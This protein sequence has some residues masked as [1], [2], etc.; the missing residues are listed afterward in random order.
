M[1]S[2]DNLS[3]A[4]QAYQEIRHELHLQEEPSFKSVKNPLDNR[5][6]VDTSIIIG[7][8]EDGQPLVINLYDYQLG[9][10]LVAGDKGC[11][12]TTFLHSTAIHSATLLDVQ[13]GV[14]TPFPEEWREH[15]TLPNCLGIWPAQHSSA[16]DFLA[17]VT[18]WAEVLPKTRQFILV[19]VDNLEMMSFHSRIRN[20]FRWLCMQGPKHHVWPVVAMNPSKINTSRSFLDQFRT[21]IL[22]HMGHYHNACLLSGEPPLDLRSLITGSQFFYTSSRNCT[23]FWL[24]PAEGLANERGNALVR[25]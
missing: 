10:V 24:P 5:T 19:L 18:H 7:L 22:G 3:I 15:E 16:G 1:S 6:Y 23:R 13:F 2:T 25:Q 4:L 14:L 21:R 11:G 8:A 20:D 9:P 12:K 17:R